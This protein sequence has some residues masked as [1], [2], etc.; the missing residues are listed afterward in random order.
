M[1]Q[2]RVSCSSVGCSMEPK[3][4]Q[5]KG[6]A[7]RLRHSCQW[8]AERGVTGRKPPGLI[9]VF[10]SRNLS[11]RNSLCVKSSCVCWSVFS[12]AT[13]YP[14]AQLKGALSVLTQNSQQRKVNKCLGGVESGQVTG[15]LHQRH[16]PRDRHPPSRPH[17]LT[18][19]LYQF[20]NPVR[21][22]KPCGPLTFSNPLT[23]HPTFTTRAF[24][25]HVIPKP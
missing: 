24:G 8:G 25:V 11:F 22:M 18:Y 20:R 4:W 10:T 17:L 7:A 14:G 15:Y 16:V 2:R 1:R 21:R 3:R 23:G 9:L 13:N 12:T 6:V 5:Q 19:I